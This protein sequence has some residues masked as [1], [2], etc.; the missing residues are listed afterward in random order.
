MNIYTSIYL[1]FVFGSVYTS[2]ILYHLH[3]LHYIYNNSILMELS[4][5][6]VCNVC[7]P[8][9]ILAIHPT[10]YTIIHLSNTLHLVIERDPR[11]DLYSPYHYMYYTVS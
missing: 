7:E 9:R 1:Y 4:Y 3:L 2:Q 10:R 6:S 5:T 11:R 8:V